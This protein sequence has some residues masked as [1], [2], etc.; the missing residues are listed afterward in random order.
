MT[1]ER[2]VPVAGWPE[3]E[4]SDMGRLRRGDRILSPGSTPKGYLRACLCVRPR[5]QW[6][7][8]I[9]KLVA[10]AFLGPR[11][12]G[13]GINHKN[14]IKTDNRADN[15]EWATI[16]ENITHAQ[17]RRLNP[18]GERH[19]N[20]VLTANQVVEIRRRRSAG[21]KGRDL[22]REFGVTPTLICLI[23]RRKAWTHVA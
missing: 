1:N 9:H 7:P 18:I 20:A 23:H 13:V 10:E 21:E 2:W 12:A 6:T 11:P 16:R 22:A 8:F 19:G 5:K 4:I 14:A 17:A 15:L 3:Y